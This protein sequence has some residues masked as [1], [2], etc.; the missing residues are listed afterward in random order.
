MTNHKDPLIEQIDRKSNAELEMETSA[1]NEW[2]GRISERHPT[3]LTAFRAGT[4][5]QLSRP[6]PAPASEPDHADA[7]KMVEALRETL[8]PDPQGFSDADCIAILLDGYAKDAGRK[9]LPETKRSYE[10]ASWLI[11]SMS[12]ALTAQ[13]NPIDD[14]SL[15][16]LVA[17]LGNQIH[18]LGC[19]QQGDEALSRRLE[20]LRSEAWRIAG[21][22]SPESPT[23]AQAL[24]VDGTISN[25]LREGDMI[26]SKAAL[27]AMRPVH[28]AGEAAAW[29]LK[30]GSGK[31]D[32]D[33][34]FQRL[35]EADKVAGWTEAPL[36][37][38]PAPASDV[39]EALAW[40]GEQ[41]CLARLIHSEGDAG[42]H[43]LAEDGGK[44]A[45]AALSTPPAETSGADQ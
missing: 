28:P 44:R 37:A 6:Q 31:Y 29:L 17:E 11:R 13:A 25:V 30:D 26:E 2:R 3:L 15:K 33:L 38:H 14:N 39:R 10:K 7:S 12:A 45:R 4:D 9:K 5:H 18:N 23:E 32:T 34:S 35:T 42:R 40:Y 8:E 1:Y 24:P 21:L 27:D 20:E 36:Y 16:A 22:S 43:A 41:A 19:E